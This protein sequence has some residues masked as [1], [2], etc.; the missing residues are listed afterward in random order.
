MLDW[1]GGAAAPA[2]CRNGT[3]LLVSDV[4]YTRLQHAQQPK[5]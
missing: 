1:A 3:T 2:D 5:R 4:D